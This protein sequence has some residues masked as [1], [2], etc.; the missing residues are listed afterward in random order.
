MKDLQGWRAIGTQYKKASD[1][2]TS[3]IAAFFL[4]PPKNGM[5]STD[6]WT[7]GLSDINHAD[8]LLTYD[9]LG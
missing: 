5:G 2:L 3:T 7:P 6:S 9:K 4:Q 8:C 1:I